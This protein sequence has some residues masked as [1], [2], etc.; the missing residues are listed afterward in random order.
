MASLHPWH[1]RAVRVSSGDRTALR[2]PVWMWR[3]AELRCHMAA[4]PR[5]C[6]SHSRGAA[7]RRPSPQCLPNPWGWEGVGSSNALDSVWLGTPLVCLRTQAEYCGFPIVV[8]QAMCGT[9]NH[10]LSN[11]AQLPLSLRLYFGSALAARC[12]QRSSAL[13]AVWP[14]R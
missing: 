8:I 4:V 12:V 1:L 5:V 2:Y 14:T 9:R 13:H 3:Q 10:V 6:V 7:A 11:L